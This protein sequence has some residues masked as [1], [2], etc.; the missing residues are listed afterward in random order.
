MLTRLALR[1]RILTIALVLVVMAAGGYS[2]SKL[3]MELYP[4]IDLPMVVVSAFYPQASPEQVLQ[5][6]TIPLEQAV[7]G[8]DNV[9]M[10]RSTSSPSVSLLIIES[11]FGKDMK[12]LERDLTRRIEAVTLGP[13][14]Q[15]PRVARMNP[16]QM[17]V[18]ELSV[19][20]SRSLADLNALVTAQV[21]PELTTVP[22]VASAE[23]PAGA[24][25]GLSITRTNGSP[26][27]SISVLKKQETNT[28]EV[29]NAVTAR[30]EAL[31]KTLPPDI[32]FIEVFN[33]GPIIQGSVDELT[34]EVLLGAVLAILV[35]FAFLLSVRP[36][37]VTSISIPASVL[38]A[39]IVMAWQ[40]ISLNIL[41]L[42]GLA[43]AVGRVVD[44]SI[45]VMENVFRHIQRGEDRRT[46]ALNG[47]REVAVPIIT[48]TLTT[49]AVFAPLALIGGFIGVIFVPFALTITYA[50][51]ASLLVAL[52]VVPVLGSLLIK[53]GKRGD[54]QD[55]LPVRV[56]SALL[57]W[58]L[59]HKVRTLLMAGAL[60]VASLAVVPLIPMTFFPGTGEP[61][62][63]VEMGVVEASGRDAVLQQLDQV[64]A[65]LETM[66]QAGEVEVY[67]SYVG[68][69]GL[70]G[71]GT[72]RFDTASIHVRLGDGKNV[73]DAAT[74]MRTALVA[75]GRTIL[76]SPSADNM[77]TNNLE[78]TLRGEDYEAL[79]ASAQQVTVALQDLPGLLNVRH[80]ASAANGNGFQAPI[81]RVDGVR[82]VTI[83]G[84]ITE[85]NTQAVQRQVQQTVDR[86]G[87]PEGVELVTGGVF[88]DMNQA[89]SQMA[90]AMLLGV[91]LVY[92]VMV[93]SQ[94]SL[95]TPLVII[96]SLPLASVGALGGLLI[97]QRTLGLPALVGILMLIGLVVTNAI[98][99]IAFVEQL[100]ARGLG[101]TE[102]LVQ[103]GRTRL[104]PI[105]MTALTTI[106]V[107][108][109]LAV[110]LGGDSAGLLGSDLATVVIG[111]LLTATLL[112]LVVV[113]VVYS[114][115]RKKGPKVRVQAPVNQSQAADPV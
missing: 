64:E 79:A 28:L 76:V 57:G 101:L 39:F 107:L 61:A 62:L 38:A 56:Y 86:V 113:P 30:L 54:G 105:L 5:D 8:A 34:Q 82:A 32:Q 13:G 93:L 69:S 49:I 19:F 110:G 33:Q 40:G 94:R 11:E 18:Q 90:L 103:G 22:G 44:D 70:F 6:V 24:A 23:V 78:L 106:F 58:S 48:S 72:G 14:V 95:L 112:T 89:F 7:L 50:L 111:G 10:V 66:R 35:I 74:A 1:A 98:V 26:S 83:T 4:D 47:T 37:L 27:L 115:L 12:A 77:G 15:A 59:A 92:V 80:D 68:N 104:R 81:S 75:P 53:Q 2:L 65:T 16:E 96:F 71:R 63:T 45:V 108:L 67:E 55:S 25:E 36:T 100:R 20:G 91:L 31:K 9:K 46:A 51:L 60:F 87:L 85:E 43:I 102:A 109:P 84:T 3:Q 73:E 88:A 42:G 21:L 29:S 114:I 41:T 99:L 97:T 52:T 17:P